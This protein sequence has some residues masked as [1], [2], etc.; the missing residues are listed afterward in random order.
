MGMVADW[1]NWSKLSWLE[2][3]RSILWG[4]VLIGFSIGS[5]LRINAFFP[6]IRSTNLQSDPSLSDLLRNTASLPVDS[7]PVRLQG[8][9]LGRQGVE[10]WLVQDLMLQTDTGLIKLHYL[11]QLGTAG[12]LLLHPQRPDLMVNTLVLVTGWFR[13]VAT[14]WIDVDTIQLKQGTTFRSGHPIASTLLTL[15]TAVW[16]VYII[17][18]GGS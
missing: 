14:P 18:R 2:G 4:L 10:S 5:L 15:V 11:S 7:Q 8:K 13:R 16:G 12:N 6:D 9:L 17:V 3:D 1:A